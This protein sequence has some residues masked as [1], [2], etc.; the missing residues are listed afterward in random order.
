[1]SC[2]LAKEIRHWIEDAMHPFAIAPILVKTQEYE[3][4]QPKPEIRSLPEE[5]AP[6]VTD[7]MYAW[8]QSQFKMA[9]PL[10]PLLCLDV[11]PFL[12]KVCE[13]L[14]KSVATTSLISLAEIEQIGWKELFANPFFQFLLLPIDQIIST[15]FLHNL[16]P[17]PLPHT[18]SAFLFPL[19]KI[20]VYLN[21]EKKKRELWES[22]KRM[23]LS[24]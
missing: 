10:T 5:K 3:P 4:P 7:P 1:M 23:P 14:T 20:E 9:K 12:K 18:P 17:N 19:E 16:L 22:L 2:E 8:A 21:D 6:N 11:H 13:A 24:S 15:P